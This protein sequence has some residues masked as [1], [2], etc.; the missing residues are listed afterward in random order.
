MRTTTTTRMKQEDDG[1]GDGEGEGEDEDEDEDEAGE[2]GSG[3]KE[4]QGGSEGGETVEDVRT[5][6]RMKFLPGGSCSPAATLSSPTALAS[7][8]VRGRM[9]KRHQD[10]FAKGLFF[11]K[12]PN[13]PSRLR[14]GQCCQ[15][16]GKLTGDPW[17]SVTSFPSCSVQQSWNDVCV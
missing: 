7:M 13:K 5:G 15:T 14:L 17:S 4:L 10:N 8:T 11:R 6:S 12:A 16:R 1:E 9:C 3:I 2:K